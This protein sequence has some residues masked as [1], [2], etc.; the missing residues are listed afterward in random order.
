MNTF[1]RHVSLALVTATVSLTTTAAFADEASDAQK[2]HT[3]RT[4]EAAA[5][6]PGKAVDASRVIEISMTDAMRFTP[7]TITVKQGQTVRFVVR[8]QGQ[9]KHELVLGSKSELKEHAQMMQ[10]MPNMEHGDSNTVALEA[11]KSGE[12]VRRFT[13]AGV[14]DFACLQPGH[15]EAGMKGAVTVAAR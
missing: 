6:L 5:G 8:N 9:L 11:G 15:F 4:T 7:S 3:K 13:Q 14:V 12:L 10:K 2:T 1:I